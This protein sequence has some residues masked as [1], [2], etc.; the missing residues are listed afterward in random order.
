MRRKRQK[1]ERER[2][3]EIAV[4]SREGRY[5][6][7][8]SMIISPKLTVYSIRY[9]LK[10]CGVITLPPSP[11]SPLPCNECQPLI[12]MSHF[13]FCAYSNFHK[14]VP[15]PTHNPPSLYCHILNLVYHIDLHI[16]QLWIY[17]WLFWTHVYRKKRR[18]RK[19]SNE[20]FGKSSLCLYFLQFNFS[21]LRGISSLGL[22]LRIKKK[23]ADDVEL[24]RTWKWETNACEYACHTKY[25]NNE[26][27]FSKR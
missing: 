8:K 13:I 14:N 25:E 3:T 27:S 23:I 22:R 19:K 26:N 15:T 2:Q 10:M 17:S 4:E 9:Q 1:R 24:R 20:L 18:K 12:L 11:T 16:Q 5:H 7:P 6:L 21:L